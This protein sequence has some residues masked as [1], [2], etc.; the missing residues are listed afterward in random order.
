[1]R[2]FSGT[3]WSERRRARCRCVISNRTDPGR[4]YWCAAGRILFG[5][6]L[7]ALRGSEAIA[8]VLGLWLGLLAATRLTRNWILLGVIGLML[9]IWMFPSH[10]MFDHVLL[11]AGIWVGTRMVEMP[12]PRRVMTAGAFVGLCAFFGRNHALYEG[13][14]Q[15]VLLVCLW[16]RLRAEVVLSRFA[17]WSLGIFLGAL[18]L[19]AMMVFVSGFF[20][21]YQ[22][23]L[24]AI[25][26]NGT[27]LALPIP[28]PWR[29]SPSGNSVVDAR[30]LILGLLIVAFP[31]TYLTG[32]TAWMMSPAGLLRKRALLATCSVIGLFYLH[33][34]YS[35][36]DLSH[37]AQASHPFTLG[38]LALGS[39]LA[40]RATYQPVMAGLLLATGLFEVLGQTPAYQ[41]L[42]SHMPWSRCEAAGG[43]FLSPGWTQ[44]LDALRRFG[45]RNIAS[46]EGVFIAPT[47]PGLYPILDRTSP[48]WELDVFFPAT[49]KRQ[50]EIIA[51]LGE[52]NVDWAIISNIPPDR[53]DD[54]RFSVTY[55]DVWRF[56]MKNFQPLAQ[57]RLPGGL[58]I[59]HRAG[60]NRV[61][62][63]RESSTPSTH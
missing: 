61:T 39:L 7:I 22:E 60:A 38:I 62:P 27:N 42:V 8:Q 24:A 20:W 23:S 17:I 45:A 33:H 6:G 21:S 53:R 15:C 11:L 57:P 14:A 28:W 35:R 13:A 16:V 47:A 59:F 1:M 36:A 26:R 31:V 43:V 9:T 34:A 40:R 25:F 32:L 18:P 51:A 19:I 56:L 5:R 46:R 55:P 48:V 2:V 58:T 10:K 52:K 44:A 4:Y 37:L 49:E 54:L 12:S 41:R 30:Q 50:K 29:F 3:A 63:A